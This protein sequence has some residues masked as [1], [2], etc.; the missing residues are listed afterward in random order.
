MARRSN[1]LIVAGLSIAMAA[2]LGSPAISAPP[3]TA[4]ATQPT[5]WDDIDQ[6]MVFFTVQLASVETSVDAANKALKGAG[7][8]IAIR[9]DDANRY[10]KGNELMDRNAGGPVRWDEFYGRTAE[11]FFYNPATPPGTLKLTVNVLR[12]NGGVAHEPLPNSN[13][14]PQFDYIYR[15]NANAKAQAEADVNKLAGKVDQLLARRR[16]LEAEQSGLWCKVAF[17]AA[18]GRE[19]LGKPLYRFDLKTNDPAATANQNLEALRAAMDFL[20]MNNKLIESAEKGVDDNQAAFIAAFQ[21]TVAKSRADFDARLMKQPTLVMD[22]FDTHTTIGKLEAVAKRMN[23]VAKNTA[24]AYKLALDAAGD[25]QRKNTFR[26]Q[27]QES[28]VIYAEAV[29]AGDECVNQLAKEW[30]IVPD[31]E[32]AA[33]EAKL[34]NL[35]TPEPHAS[36]T[37]QDDSLKNSKIG[38]SSI[39]NGGLSAGVNSIIIEAFIDG[40]SELHLKEDGIYWVQAASPSKPGKWH[41][42]H[43]PTFVDGKAWQPVWGKPNVE[44]GKDRSE[45]FAIPLKGL[46]FKLKLLAVA[47]QRGVEQIDQRTPVEL[48]EESGEQIITIPDPETGAKWYTFKLYRGT[49]QDS[50]RISFQKS[51]S[52]EVAKDNSET[53]KTRLISARWGGDRKMLNVNHQAADLLAKNGELLARTREFGGDPTP[54]ERKYLDIVLD[55]GGKTIHRTVEENKGF[56]LSTAINDAAQSSAEETADGPFSRSKVAVS[57]E[58]RTLPDGAVIVSAFWGSGKRSSDVTRAVASLLERG[59]DFLLT[60]ENLG[61]DPAPMHG[62]DL[63][64]N[65]RVDGKPGRRALHDGDIFRV[66]TGTYQPVISISKESNTKMEADSVSPPKDIPPRGSGFRTPRNADQAKDSTRDLTPQKI[67]PGGVFDFGNGPATP[68]PAT[69]PAGK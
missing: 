36:L 3:A 54:F 15:A 61:E 64:V 55:V 52:N 11:K 27:L 33:P 47:D 6:R 37:P 59:D 1:L 19:L 10:Q 4:P 18:A 43:E 62:K 29:M 49:K 60:K 63:E 30:K 35:P 5:A 57:A 56:K 51:G 40:D 44:T 53:D 24:D 28:L 66:A 17:R 9:A 42:H 32:K 58:P 50:A 26:G 2:I 25:E 69:Q 22:A 41:G 23:D 38:T 48:S 12:S 20:R 8:K 13:R 14:P 68:A 16:Q 21:E 34:P 67:G 65:F 31:L 46:G 7:Y 39:P 45:G